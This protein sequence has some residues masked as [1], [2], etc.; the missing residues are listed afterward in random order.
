MFVNG[1]SIKSPLADGAGRGA[2]T[3]GAGVGAPGTAAG[4]GT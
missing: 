2:A 4:D 1:I 3:A